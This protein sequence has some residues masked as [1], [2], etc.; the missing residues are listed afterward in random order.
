MKR[1][2]FFGLTI[3]VVSL[4][5]TS[6]VKQHWKTDNQPEK[7]MN[8]VIVDPGP[9]DLSLKV[10]MYAG[11]LRGHADGPKMKAQ[12]DHIVSM[13]SDKA[14]NLYITDFW[15]NTIRKI[16]PSGL[17]NIYAGNG[18]KGLIDGPALN[19]Q[20][21]SPTGLTFD[22][23]GNMYF[24]QPQA[25]RKI[26]TSG[27]VSTVAFCSYPSLPLKDGP[28]SQATFSNL[29]SVCVDSLGNIYFTDYSAIRK[30]TTRGYVSTL[31]GSKSH[32]IGYTDGEGQ[33]A[34]FG[35]K[36][37][38]LNIDSKGNLFV[39]DRTNHVIRKITP[40]GVVSTFCGNGESDY[41]DGIGKNARL[42]AP[43]DLAIDAFDNIYVADEDIR[44]IRKINAAGKIET[45]A[46]NN[47]YGMKGGLADQAEFGWMRGGLCLFANSFLYV[48]ECFNDFEADLH[49]CYI[50]KVGY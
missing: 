49:Y 31:A 28:L 33:G 12:F 10:Y 34:K 6:C 42:K 17:V 9:M 23:Y 44:A 22:P 3:I 29:E 18:V 21:Y 39:S 1:N 16:A 46:G 5:L 41:I 50:R 14:G 37:F 43:R 36:L 24:V 11:G 48:S 19:A 25:I 47:V 20:L 13:A 35:N 40:A 8:D 7:S 4:N 2:D 26:N 30:I 15:Y 45:Y 38:G 27:I 32:E